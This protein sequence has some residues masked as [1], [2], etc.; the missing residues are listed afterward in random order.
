VFD[1]RTIRASYGRTKYCKFFLKSQ[2]CTKRDCPYK[3]SESKESDILTPDDMQKKA[4]FQYCQQL[5]IQISNVAD[6]PEPQFRAMLKHKEDQL[7]TTESNKT[8]LPRPESIF[9]NKDL[10]KKIN[11]AR[12][13]FK[14]EDKKK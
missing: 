11:L 5:A 3:H 6:L 12:T 1:S 14:Q 2:A 4:L 7:L 8:V 9:E 10:M 13:I